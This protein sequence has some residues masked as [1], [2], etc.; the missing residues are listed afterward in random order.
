MQTPW[1]YSFHNP[2]R[3]HKI[4]IRQIVCIFVLCKLMLL[5]LSMLCITDTPIFA[6]DHI[7]YLLIYF[8][9]SR[10]SMYINMYVY[11]YQYIFIYIYLL[12]TETTATKHWT[13]DRRADHVYM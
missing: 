10:R 3:H 7:K 2:H 4:E 1:I 13:L 9:I 8:V 5:M 11:I 12:Y 6:A